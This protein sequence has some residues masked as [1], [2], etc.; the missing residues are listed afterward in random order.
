[1][2]M[3][4]RI[5]LRSYLIMR[6]IECDMVRFLTGLGFWTWS[7]WHGAGGLSPS[8]SLPSFVQITSFHSHSTTLRLTDISSFDN[9]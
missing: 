2:I 6:G 5:I 4:W 9:A 1:M 7:E 8:R 3:D